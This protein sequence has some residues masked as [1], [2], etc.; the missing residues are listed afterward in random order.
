LATACNSAEDLYSL[1]CGRTALESA[2]QTLLSSHP[3]GTSPWLETWHRLS[4]AVQGL[5]EPLAKFDLFN[6][7]AIA[8]VDVGFHDVIAIAAS[9]AGDAQMI[10][11][12]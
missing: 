2:A 5:L 9:S 11:L 1:A 6:L 8:F 7:A 10:V 4:L 3:D 12:I